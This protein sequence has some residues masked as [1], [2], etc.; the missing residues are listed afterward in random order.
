MEKPQGEVK[1]LTKNIVSYKVKQKR[2]CFS[3]G[4]KL[5]FYLKEREK[6]YGG[7]GTLRKSIKNTLPFFCCFAFLFLSVIFSSC[8]TVAGGG[9]PSGSSGGNG[10]PITIKLPPIGNFAIRA[11]TEEQVSRLQRDTKKYRVTFSGAGQTITREGE[12]TTFSAI[13]PVGTLVDVTVYCLNED[14]EVIVETVTKTITVSA[15]SNSLSFKL[16]EDGTEVYP[17]SQEFAVTYAL[18]GGSWSS[19]QPGTV[20]YAEGD[21]VTITASVPTQQGFTFTGWKASG[22]LAPSS[23]DN[24][25]P[26][27]TFSMPGEPVTLTAQWMLAKEYVN[28]SFKQ[29]FVYTNSLNQSSDRW[30]GMTGATLPSDGQRE[31]GSSASSDSDQ[32]SATD[33]VFKGWVENS[34]SPSSGT[35]DT[36]NFV[37]NYSRN[38]TLYGIW[39]QLEPNSHEVKF[40]TGGA[41]VSNM[42]K[43]MQGTVTTSVTFTGT[44]TRQGYTFTSWSASVSSVTVTQQGS[45]WTFT[46]PDAAVTITAQWTE[47]PTLYVGGSDA[48]DSANDGSQA[49]PFATLQKAFEVAATL[50]ASAQRTIMVQSALSKTVA[51]MTRGTITLDLNSKTITGNGNSSVITINGGSLTLDGNGTITGGGGAEGGGVYVKSGATFTMSGGTISGNA[52]TSKGGGIYVASGATFTLSNGTI[53]N[54]TSDSSSARTYGAGVYNAGTFAMN[55]GSINANTL[56]ASATGGT[57]WGAGSAVYN[58][59]KFTMSNGIMDGNIAGQ[60]SSGKSHT[61]HGTG[62]VYNEGSKCTFTMSGGTISNNKA[63]QG[64][65]V[66]MKNSAT[67]TMTNGTITGNITYIGGGVTFDSYTKGNISGGSITANTATYYAGGGPGL[68]IRGGSVV[69]ATIRFGAGE[70]SISDVSEEKPVTYNGTKYTASATL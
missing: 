9:S 69:T 27:A 41:N 70:V 23:G 35:P 44:P 45:D 66:F 29:G 64:G 43:N 15:G 34:Q 12:E 3:F 47:M 30:Q 16:S 6:F 49:K 31:K 52:V 62:T 50:T 63:E 60:L 38:M 40:E 68:R 17:E 4:G 2:D 11:L 51:T 32:A 14:G 58:A 61:S 20:Q 21:T 36:Q 26:N 67:F 28:I 22:D 39:E 56:A 55:G 54:N 19:A 24:F 65:G 42:P 5:C 59:S 8:D 57:V 18:A 10:V 46:M 53:S 25:Q 33:Y 1:L 37:Q 7:G 48:S 13:F